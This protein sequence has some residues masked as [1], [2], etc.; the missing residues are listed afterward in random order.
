VA[1]EASEDGMKLQAALQHSLHYN[2][3][4]A[5]LSGRQPAPIL[6]LRRADG[7]R[8]LI[9]TALG[10][11]KVA[12][13]SRDAAVILHVIDPGRDFSTLIAPLCSIYKLTKV[14]TR[15]AYLLTSGLTLA[16]AAETMKVQEATARTYLKQIFVK[17][18]TNRQADLVRLM[19]S[20][21]Q[22]INPSVEL[23]PH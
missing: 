7:Q 9:V 10:L 2:L 20:S 5:R 11:D 16:T 17:T 8:S 22:H 14:E 15:L 19:L 21:L 6:A 1:A 3:A 12:I 18:F 13:D 23:E 4:R